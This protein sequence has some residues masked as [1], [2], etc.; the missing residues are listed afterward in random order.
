MTVAAKDAS[1]SVSLTLSAQ[2]LRAG[3]AEPRLALSKGARQDVAAEWFVLGQSGQLVATEEEA[4]QQ[5][6]LTLLLRLQETP[7][8]MWKQLFGELGVPPFQHLSHHESAGAILFVRVSDRLVAWT[9]GTGFRWLSRRTTDPR[10]GLLVALNALAEAGE[11]AGGLLAARLAP[12]EGDLRDASLRLS[13]PTRGPIARYDVTTDRLKG[14]VANTPREGLE[15]VSG[16]QSLRFSASISGLDDFQALSRELV[17]LR[18]SDVYKGSFSYVENVV[19]EDDPQ[20]VER[21]VREV[22]QRSDPE[23]GEPDVILAW[24]DEVLEPPEDRVVTHFRLPGDRRNTAVPPEQRPRSIVLTW[25]GVRSALAARFGEEEPLDLLTKEIRFFDSKD[26]EVGSCEILDLLVADLTVD[27]AHYL[28]SEGQVFRVDTDYLTALDTFL[29]G[30]VVRPS[31]LPPYVGGAEDTYNTGSGLAVLDR[32]LIVVD[33]SRL[34]L[35]DLVDDEGRMIFV[36]R[37]ARAS[38]MSHLWAQVVSSFLLLRRSAEARG[39][40]LERLKA[41]DGAPEALLQAIEDGATNLTLVLAILGATDVRHLTLLARIPLRAAIQR[42][43][44]AGA[45]VQ[46]ELVPG[47]GQCHQPEEAN[48]AG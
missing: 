12:T 2:L 41:A 18:V 22:W 33:G 11:D 19:E 4:A 8:P 3:I 25:Q 30:L 20:T 14:V 7:P 26:E 45:E 9:F 46:I 32:Q 27:G 29:D 28:V 21:V 47:P 17:D 5:E 40:A 39:A 42:L 43:Q 37:R 15:R 36:K 23:S 6:P 13:S 34:E 35:C 1:K 44:D 16:G 48:H 31:R 38:A 24:W 10:F